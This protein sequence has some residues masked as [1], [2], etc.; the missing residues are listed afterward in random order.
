MIVNDNA[1]DY[2][3]AGDERVLRSGRNL[4]WLRGTNNGVRE[5]LSDPD[6][7]FVCM[8]NNDV[9]LAG[10]F[11]AGLVA[12]TREPDVGL[13]A[14]CYDDTFPAQTGYWTGPA[15]DFPAEPVEVTADVV[16]GTCMLLPVAALR[17]VGLLDE[18]HFGL[19]GWGGSDDLC[20]RLQA[21]G[22]R[23]VVTH[24]AYLQH[25][26]GA[27]LNQLYTDYH[28]RA[29]AEMVVGM[30]RKYGRDW[31]ARFPSGTF[32]HYDPSLR[33]YARNAAITYAERLRSRW[34]AASA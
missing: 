22:R 3:P 30:R 17:D 16:D 25:Q 26:A 32:D 2:V 7:R 6:V 19:H 29:L 15:G 27:T 34:P 10:G 31:P 1:G 4:G 14:P 9:T 33:D 21:T 5:A 20:L 23:V 8:M 28:R 13:V 18:R 24:R 11:L 12:A